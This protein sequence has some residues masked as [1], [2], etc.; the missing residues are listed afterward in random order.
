MCKKSDNS[1]LNLYTACIFTRNTGLCKK[2]DKAKVVKVYLY[3]KGYNPL[4][5]FSIEKE[6]MMHN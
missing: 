2:S 6:Q 5:M 3:R 4:Q 1:R